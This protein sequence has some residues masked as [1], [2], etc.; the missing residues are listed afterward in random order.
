VD[1]ILWPQALALAFT[2]VLGIVLLRMLLALLGLVSSSK[3]LTRRSQHNKTLAVGHIFAIAGYGLVVYGQLVYVGT[4]YQ[5]P[6]DIAAVVCL[7]IGWTSV[8]VIE[9]RIRRA[10]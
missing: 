2:V 9:R 4:K 1:N 8:F 6:M 5:I 10:A 3:R 7:F